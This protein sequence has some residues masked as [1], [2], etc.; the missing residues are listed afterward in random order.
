MTRPNTKTV[1]LRERWRRVAAAVAG[2]TWLHAAL[3]CP[4]FG[5]VPGIDEP[6]VSHEQ[7]ASGSGEPVDLDLCCKA[8]GDSATVLQA[9][10]FHHPEFVT[11][12]APAIAFT[13]ALLTGQFTVLP[14]DRPPLPEETELRAKRFVSFSSQAPPH[15]HV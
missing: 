4:S 1:G 12:P 3:T 11:T 15:A 13:H 2:A 14:L 7:G 10:H 5:P 9:L 6:V 8:L